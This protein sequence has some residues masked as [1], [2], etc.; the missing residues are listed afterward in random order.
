MAGGYM[1]APPDAALATKAAK[2]AAKAGRRANNKAGGTGGAGSTGGTA[3]AAGGFRQYVSP[4]GYQVSGTEWQRY[5]QYVD[6]GG[7]G[8]GCSFLFSFLPAYQRAT[9]SM[10][11]CSLPLHCCRSFV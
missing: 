4:G 5:V 9:S 1:R 8:P 7:R 2:A 10:L 3:T 6:G 11:A